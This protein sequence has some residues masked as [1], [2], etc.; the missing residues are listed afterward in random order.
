MQHRPLGTRSGLEVAEIS[1][2]AMRLPKEGNEGVKM[3]RHAI[4]SGMCY[5]DT[6]FTYIGGESEVMVGRAA[7][8]EYRDKIHVSTKFHTGHHKNG[9]FT[10]DLAYEQI[11][12]QMKRM[13]LD[14]LDFFQI[15]GL[16]S[17]EMWEA[18]TKPGGFVDGIKRAMDE[19]L[20]RHT[21]F[22]THLLPE[23][24]NP[25]LEEADW[26]EV[27]LV[28]YNMLDR[29]RE[30]SLA[31]CKQLGIGTLV[32]NPV[33]GG[34][35]SG[36]STVLQEIVD[37]VGTESLADLAIR[38][39]L[40]NPN[41]DSSVCGMT[42]MSDVDDSIASAERG[43][44]TAEQVDMVNEFIGTR[45]RENAAFCTACEYCMPCPEE[46]KIPKIMGCI[47]DDKYL[48]L[49]ESAIKEYRAK[50]T[51]EKKAESCTA[52][53]QCEEK[54]PQNLKIAD[55][56]QYALANYAEKDS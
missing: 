31:L 54:C 48:G 8:D 28:G 11:K 41:V 52:C 25:M 26:C 34:K 18:V 42:R 36:T 21:G 49:T 12:T 10:A 14:C 16:N 46:I 40:A 4:D 33:A 56:M 9:E 22:T 45:S 30:E 6:S 2:G 27:V 38:Y 43:P 47:Y 1:I 51:G 5:V 53:K 24:L 44:L 13:K 37:K 15:W 17:V 23:D 7:Q 39:V 35:L 20:V 19:G 3:L 50:W 55:E 29:T 32:M